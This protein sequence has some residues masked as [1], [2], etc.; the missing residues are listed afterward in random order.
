MKIYIRLTDTKYSMKINVPKD[1]KLLSISFLFIFLGFNGVQ[2]YVTTYFYEAGFV[3]VGFRSLIIVYLFFALSNP[4][5]AVFV[6]R[7]GPKKSMITGAIFYSVFI[8]SLAFE[9]VV[10]V[11]FS[12]LML[13][14]AASLLWT[15]QNVYLIRASDERG[16]GKSAGFFNSLHSLGGGA[17][18]L[19]MGFLIAG[20]SFKLPFLFFSVFPLI[21]FFLLF[22]LRDMRCEERKNRFE[23]VKKSVTNITALKL[24]VIW[25]SFNFV[26]GLVIGIV[27]IEI[28][29][30]LGISYVAVLGTLFYAMPILFS[31]LFGSVSDIAGRKTMIIYS[32]VLCIAGL[33]L[34]YFSGKVMLIAGIVLLAV[35]YSIV[36]P[37]TFALVGDVTTKKNV[38]FLT[39]LFWMVQNIGVIFALIISTIVDAKIVYLIS[40]AVMIVSLAVLIPLFRQDM[41]E[42]RERLSL[43][44][45]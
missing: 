28:K 13:G 3:D 37:M 23:L 40:V 32:Y 22:G 17:G 8:F 10:F 29:D 24:S 9:S 45:K 35:N 7:Y 26:Y 11:Y 25:F 19:F 44:V 31:Y 21:G 2:Q 34:L 4:F 5:S 27:P 33:V 43:E 41:W 14:I 16:Y 1:V 12:S 36:R 42:I 38:E 20:F 15:G 30:T 39:A 6:S 18:V